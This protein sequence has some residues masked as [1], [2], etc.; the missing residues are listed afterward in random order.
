MTLK[1]RIP[2]LLST[3]VSNH[4][5]WI[6]V[7]KSCRGWLVEETMCND[8]CLFLKAALNILSCGHCWW[9]IS[10]VLCSSQAY[11]FGF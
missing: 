2:L 3:Q 1:E 7:G 8:F 11:S 10:L 6:M 9:Q 5:M 4:E